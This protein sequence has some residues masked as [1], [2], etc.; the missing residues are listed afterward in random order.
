M[1]VLAKILTKYHLKQL[2]EASYSLDGTNELATLPRALSTENQKQR[3][4]MSEGEESTPKMSS[5]NHREV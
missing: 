1:R 4:F 2:K 3:Q 5:R